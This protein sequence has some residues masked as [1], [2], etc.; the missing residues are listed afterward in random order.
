MKHPAIFAALIALTAPHGL[1]AQ[2]EAAK[3]APPVLGPQPEACVDGAVGP[4]ALVHVT[5]FKDR[6]GVLRVELYPAVEN[7]FL[8]SGTKLKSEGK[9]FQRIDN[10]TPQQGDGVVCV[11][12]PGTGPFAIAVLHD[13]NSNGKLDAF[14]DGFGFPNNPRLGYGKPAASEAT[15]NAGAGVIKLDIVLN[16]WNGLSA[17]PIRR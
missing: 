14:S 7:D 1:W 5:G 3:E 15:F 12:L 6:S 4:A 11:A 8:A 2:D 9:V 13:R 10:P 16:Y 17:R